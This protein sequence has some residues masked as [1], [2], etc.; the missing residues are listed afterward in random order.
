MGGDRG[1][2]A[3]IPNSTTSDAADLR[4]ALAP[5]Q[6][7]LLD[8]AATQLDRLVNLLIRFEVEVAWVRDQPQDVLGHSSGSALELL[9]LASVRASEITLPVPRSE[10]AEAILPAL[11]MDAIRLVGIRLPRRGGPLG[12]DLV[13]WFDQARHKFDA[14][15]YRGAIERARDGAERGREAAPGDAKRSGGGEGSATRVAC[16]RAQRRP[17]SWMGSGGHWRR[18]PMRRITLATRVA[19]PSPPL[20]RVRSSSPPRSSSSIWAPPS[21]P[22]RYERAHRFGRRARGATGR[23]GRVGACLYGSGL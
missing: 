12:D 13:A 9:P 16:R 11:G 8:V 17:P 23:R 21:R 2:W 7:H 14:G 5:L 3:S 19:D 15:E 6:V 18:R 20:M 4:F 10:W 22:E 1:V